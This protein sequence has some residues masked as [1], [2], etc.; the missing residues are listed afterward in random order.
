M[1]DQ[2]ASRISGRTRAAVSATCVRAVR[3]TV[4][5][6]AGNF[7]RDK[8][9]DLNAEKI[10]PVKCFM[11]TRC[12]ICCVPAIFEHRRGRL[13]SKISTYGQL[14]EVAVYFA[15]SEWPEG[16]LFCVSNAVG[17][18]GTMKKPNRKK[19]ANKP[20]SNAARL[21]EKA[22]AGKAVKATGKRGA[23]RR[24]AA[25]GIALVDG[26]GAP[27]LSARRRTLFNHLT[28][29]RL[30]TGIAFAGHTGTAVAADFFIPRLLR[31]VFTDPPDAVTDC[32]GRIGHHMF[33]PKRIGIT[34]RSKRNTTFSS[35]P[36]QGH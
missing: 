30:F 15:M 5:K 10:Q 28:D 27:A 13:G 36:D 33:P 9:H 31:V 8:C 26:F 7:T 22:E 4:L 2:A 34:S 11:I 14:A 18:G 29:V 35:R 6:S 32:A 23:A 24:A 12:G 3:I 21:R 16:S 17:K 1:H 25:T 19:P 20:K